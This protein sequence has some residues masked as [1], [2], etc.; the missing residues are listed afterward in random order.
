MKKITVALT[1]LLICAAA[2]AQ[3]FIGGEVHLGVAP[4]ENVEKAKAEKNLFIYPTIG[5]EYDDHWEFGASF[6]F[7]HRRN[8]GGEYYSTKYTRLF[9]KPFARYTFWDNGVRFEKG[10]LSAFVQGNLLFDKLSQPYDVPQVHGF[11]TFERDRTTLGI[12]I[13]PGIKYNLTE[14]ITIIGTFGEL[15]A[16]TSSYMSN[17]RDSSGQNHKITTKSGGFGLEFESSLAVSIC[18][19]FWK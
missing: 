3:T 2:N 5:Y 19:Y 1:A 6:G 17:D 12:T 14:N 16:K 8:T 13:N 15:Y 10:D 18:Y 9:V 11:K 4:Y 7:G